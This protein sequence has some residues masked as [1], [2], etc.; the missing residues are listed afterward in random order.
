MSANS[1][2]APEANAAGTDGAPGAPRRSRGPK[3]SIWARFDHAVVPYVLI[4]PFFILFVA[5]GIFPIVYS[6]LISFQTFR[7]VTFPQ[8]RT[9]LLAGGLLAFA[10]SFDE[11]VV[12]VFTAGA[13]QT[14]PIWIFANLFRPRE[15]PIV[16]VVSHGTPSRAMRGGRRPGK[17]DDR[18]TDVRVESTRGGPLSP[19]IPDR[20]Q[21]GQTRHPIAG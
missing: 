6:G 11:V 8:M 13:Q 2:E 18:A 1:V 17:Q 5:F 20:A 4:S 12:T 10:L 15:Q 16:N 21:T 14:L 19:D 7:F 3:S 9:A